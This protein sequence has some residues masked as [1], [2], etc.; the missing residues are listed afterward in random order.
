MD[1]RGSCPARR[2]CPRKNSTKPWTP[3]KPRATSWTSCGLPRRSNSAGVVPRQ[4]HHRHARLQLPQR[5]HDQRAP[6]V[7]RHDGLAIRPAQ[8]GTGFFERLQPGPGLGEA[9]IHGWRDHRVRDFQHALVHRVRQQPACRHIR[10]V[11]HARLHQHARHHVPRH[12]T[13]SQFAMEA[14]FD[15]Q[16]TSVFPRRIAELAEIPHAHAVLVPRVHDHMLRRFQAARQR[17]VARQDAREQQGRAGLMHGMQV[18]QPV[19][20]LHPGTQL[21]AAPAVRRRG[22]IQAFGAPDAVHVLGN[23]ARRI[24]IGVVEAVECIQVAEC[25][26]QAAA[27]RPQPRRQQVLQ[28]PGT[29]KL[30]AMHQRGYHQCA[31]RKA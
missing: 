28:R 19:R 23:E 20:A 5:R 25:Q 7:R 13:R 27:T 26:R 6:I 31:P 10:G 24:V 29:A 16:G 21:R 4:P 22:V 15:Q 3:P 8:R 14:A 1:S 11:D 12:V 30:I 17:D 18:Q 9:Q 2:N